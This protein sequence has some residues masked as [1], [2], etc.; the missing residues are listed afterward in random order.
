MK[1]IIEMD[2]SRERVFVTI[3]CPD[4]RGNEP[5]YNGTALCERKGDTFGDYEKTIA[6]PLAGFI[7]YMKGDAKNFTKLIEECLARENAH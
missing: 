1:F 4:I 7:E 3:A 5:L 2:V 6:M